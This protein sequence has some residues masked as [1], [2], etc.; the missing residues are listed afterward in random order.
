MPIWTTGVVGV[1][2]I[3]GSL[4]LRAP[5]SWWRDVVGGQV[6]EPSCDLV[7]H[8]CWCHCCIAGSLYMY[9][10]CCYQVLK[11]RGAAFSV[12]DAASAS[13]PGSRSPT[14]PSLL[15]WLGPQALLRGPGNCVCRQHLSPPPPILPSLC[16]PK[17][18][19]SDV[20]LC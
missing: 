7:P 12:P 11:Q 1:P 13:S 5:L 18:T 10:R 15:H 20:P 3:S 17:C 4:G 8:G 2:A 19:P 16:I 6:S 14:P 9:L